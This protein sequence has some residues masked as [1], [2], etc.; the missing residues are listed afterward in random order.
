MST[1]RA[2]PAAARRDALPLFAALGDGTRLALVER[3]AAADGT[4]VARLA[5][6]SA[7]TRQALAKHL[8]VLERAGLARSERRGRE[9]LWRLRRERLVD[10][11]D[12]LD[13]IARHWD[14]ALA[15]LA[16]HVEAD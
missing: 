3:L 6:R 9:R 11:Q 13:A 4:T 7:I 8:A 10:A 1:R 12:Y 5:E 16:R 15:R 14:D 2:L